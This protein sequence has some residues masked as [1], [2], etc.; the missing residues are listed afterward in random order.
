MC[1]AADLGLLDDMLG[2]QLGCVARVR[3]QEAVHVGDD[4]VFLFRVAVL[5]GD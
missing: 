3:D 5:E 1:V 4:E 2:N